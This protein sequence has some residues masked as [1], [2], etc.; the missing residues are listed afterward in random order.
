MARSRKIRLLYAIAGAGTGNFVRSRAILTELDPERFEITMV[1][2]ARSYELACNLYPTHRLE[3]VVYGEGEFSFPSILRANLSFP[4]KF[5]RNTALCA[6]I[7][8][9][10]QPDAVLVDSDFYCF[11]PAKRRGIPVISINSAQATLRLFQDFHPGMGRMFFS[12]NFIERL[13]AWLQRRYASW[14][15]CPVVKKLPLACSKIRQ[16]HP[17][18]RRAFLDSGMQSAP[19]NILYDVAVMTGG[20]G[21]GTAH[22][23]LSSLKGRCLVMGRS[24]SMKLPA[25]S[26]ILEYDDDPVSHLSKAWILVVQGGFNSVSEVLALR[27]PSVLVPIP[28]HAEQYVNARS[29][30]SLGVGI[31]SEGNKVAGAVLRIQERYG[32]FLAACRKVPIICD[33]ARQAASF[34]EEWTR[35]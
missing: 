31:M 9:R 16:I 5:R 7:L 23:D 8:D 18:V 29:L 27:T 32:E 17:I 24:G 33:G 34:I 13:D 15:L 10:F 20:S 30:E 14:I 26:Q 28:N 21:I 25:D 6:E 12:H 22:M 2:Q 35:A 19:Q 4:A 11:F 1:A 3:D